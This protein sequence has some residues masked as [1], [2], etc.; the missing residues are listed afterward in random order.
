MP[1]SRSQAAGIFIRRRWRVIEIH[2]VGDQHGG[3]AGAQAELVGGGRID[4][5][6][7]DGRQVRWKSHI[8]I[9]PD[10]IHQ[11]ALALP[12]EVVMMSD[13]RHTGLGDEFSQRDPQREIE[14]DRQDILCDQQMDVELFGKSVQDAA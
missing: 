4:Y 12:K 3:D 2:H 5:H 10:T 8:E 1:I 6:M 11:E 9:I 13:H 7:A 14:R